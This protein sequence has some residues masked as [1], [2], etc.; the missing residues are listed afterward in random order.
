MW[1]RGLRAAQ[2]SAISSELA[3]D[4]CC[5]GSRTALDPD[6]TPLGHMDVRRM[7][8]E[9]AP[10]RDLASSAVWKGR[11][12]SCD[13]PAMSLVSSWPPSA[14]TRRPSEV[15]V[16]LRLP[17]KWR[18]G[19]MSS[20]ASTLAA[21]RGGRGWLPMVKYVGRGTSSEPSMREEMVA[22]SVSGEKTSPVRMAME[23]LFL[24]WRVATFLRAGS[25]SP[26]RL[27]RTILRGEKK[28]SVR[29]WI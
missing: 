5:A 7:S 14:T 24:A 22:S 29:Y 18:F 6:H 11:C 16:T 15:L 12:C 13:L 10:R 17:R 4:A 27:P 3:M 26:L 28:R 9:L 21:I 2:S 19:Q 25:R 20:S 23:K 8:A 1:Y